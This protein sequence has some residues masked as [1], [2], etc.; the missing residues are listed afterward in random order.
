[1]ESI[2]DNFVSSSESCES[3][4]DKK[5]EV[6][7]QRRGRAVRRS[8]S[9]SGFAEAASQAQWARTCSRA[10]GTQLARV[11]RSVCQPNEG[12]YQPGDVVTGFR[13]NDTKAA[14]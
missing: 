9:Q 8:H 5:L 7:T 12:V 3:A 2:R 1:M 6:S 10:L 13:P 4:P 11:S 14:S